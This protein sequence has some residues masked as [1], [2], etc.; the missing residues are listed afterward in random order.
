MSFLTQMV[1]PII[2]PLSIDLYIPSEDFDY[3]KVIII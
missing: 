1:F 2:A 3:E